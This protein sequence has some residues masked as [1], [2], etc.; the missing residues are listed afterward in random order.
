MSESSPGRRIDAS[1]PLFDPLSPDQ[2]IERYLERE[3]LHLERDDPGL[4]EG[5]FD[6]ESMGHCLQYMRPQ[7]AGGIRV[8]APDGGGDKT[9]MLSPAMLKER[10]DGGLALLRSAFADRHTIV[11]V[12]AQNYWRPVE[13]IIVDLQRTLRSTVRC[14]VYC[15][16]PASQGF[17]TH[18]DAHD[19][20]VL[21]TSGSKTWRLHDVETELPIERSALMDE[22]HPRLRDTLPD[23]GEPTREVVL[24]PGDLLYLPRGVPHSAAST[25]DHSVHLT[26]GLYPLRLHEMLG[27][28]VDL[29]AFHSVELRRRTPIS[30][31]S[32]DAP[33]AG[34]LLREVAALADAVDP[35]IDPKRLLEV[36]EDSEAPPPDS[37]GSFA[38]ALAARDV[39]LHTVLERPPGCEW[40]TRRHRDEF[41]VSCG[42]R[43]ALPLKLAPVLGFFETHPRFRVGD[44]P[45]I[46]SDQAKITLARH[47]LLHD[48]LRIGDRSAE[49]GSTPRPEPVESLPWLHPQIPTTG[50]A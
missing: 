11:F 30:Y 18:V 3:V 45:R 4:V 24:R 26:I 38:S 33:T 23:H 1:G 21:Q 40:R 47:L 9:A 29:V 7:L 46:L 31:Y 20:L 13:R 25:D 48:V 10:R 49:L 6:L 16:P 44:L 12:G 5:I 50:Q 36:L 41:R 42:G 32:G 34:D 27:T 14:N 39:D 28:L 15:T 2:F 8:V 35:P 22:F 43:M 17:D 37:A 19:V